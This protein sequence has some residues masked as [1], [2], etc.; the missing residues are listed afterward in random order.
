VSQEAEGNTE[1]NPLKMMD[2]I[3]D[4]GFF[5]HAVV[6]VLSKSCGE[7]IISHWVLAGLP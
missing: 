2:C 6:G 4:S 7:M 1:I 3:G 5:P